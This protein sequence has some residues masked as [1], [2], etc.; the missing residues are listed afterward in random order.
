N[1][2]LNGAT[3][4][5]ATTSG[6]DIAA[7]ATNITVAD[8]TGWLNGDTLLIDTEPVTMTSVP[9]GN[10]FNISPTGSAHFSSNTIRVSN[11]DRNAVVR[12]SATTSNMSH[13]QNLATNAT[14]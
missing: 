9:S 13:I 1:F 14:S 7:G 11:M 3:K 12:S 6:N 2:I 5:V 8:T 10:N 4:T